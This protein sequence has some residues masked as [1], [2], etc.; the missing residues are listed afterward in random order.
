MQRYRYQL[1]ML[2]VVL[3]VV[4]LYLFNSQQPPTGRKQAEQYVEI[5]LYSPDGFPGLNSL[6]TLTIGNRRFQYGGFKDGSNKTLI[7]FLTLEEFASVN[8]GDR[9]VLFY[10]MG[11]DFGV[12]DKTN[13]KMQEQARY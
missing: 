6:P 3:L 2:A 8:N 7:F 5:E 9:V 11:R 10:S 1:I 13:L 4:L 12:L